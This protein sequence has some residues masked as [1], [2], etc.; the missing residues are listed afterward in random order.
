MPASTIIIPTHNRPQFL[1]RLLLFLS[2]VQCPSSIVVVDSSD[3]SNASLSA[4]VVDDVQSQLP[5]NY[6]HNR[7]RFEVKCMETLQAT[8]TPYVVLC[9]DDDFINPFAIEPCIS[10]LEDNP[11]YAIARGVQFIQTTDRERRIKPARFRDLDVSDPARRF[12]YF[13]DNWYST[14]YCVHRTP[15][16]LSDFQITC[17]HTNSEHSI[18]LPELLL[19]YLSVI[20]GCTRY[21][22]HF[23]GM[24][25]SH[26]NA[27]SCIAPKITDTTNYDAHYRRFTQCVAREL[28]AAS[29]LSQ[30]ESNRLVERCHGRNRATWESGAGKKQSG[31]A[32]VI[33]EIARPLRKAVSIFRHG[34]MRHNWR[35][36][37]NLKGLENDDI[38]RLMAQLIDTFPGGCDIDPDWK[39]GEAA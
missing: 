36:H 3:S 24:R 37:P 5:I 38:Y 30:D 32:G 27:A 28:S 34:S 29:T 8:L 39:N 14:F 25:Q 13:S 2:R 15:E 7:Q 18:I 4:V 23:Y 11:D 26:A 20:R 33:R 1:K 22:P 10:F 35:T 31:M 17:E 21:L 12:S 6:I 16:L 9:A 19:T